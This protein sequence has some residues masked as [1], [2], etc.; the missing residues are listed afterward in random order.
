[1]IEGVLIGLGVFAAVCV[2][3]GLLALAGYLFILNMKS[4]N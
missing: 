3:A 1:V 2:I 4:W